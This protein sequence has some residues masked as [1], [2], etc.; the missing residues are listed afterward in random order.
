MQYAITKRYK[1][2]GKIEVLSDNPIESKYCFVKVYLPEG[3][4]NLTDGDPILLRHL[5]SGTC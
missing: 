1:K 4:P 3:D 5:N 2:N